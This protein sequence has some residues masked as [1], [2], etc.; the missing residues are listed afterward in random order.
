[1][2]IAIRNLAIVCTYV[3][4]TASSDNNC[5]YSFKT[6][7]AIIRRDKLNAQFIVTKFS[8][9]LTGRRSLFRLQRVYGFGGLER[10]NGMVEWTGLDWT[11]MEWN[12][13]TR[14]M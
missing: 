3:A 14:G 12:G 8:I 4:Q 1:M 6:T 11:G 5:N 2:C 7:S 10:W 9:L 13:M